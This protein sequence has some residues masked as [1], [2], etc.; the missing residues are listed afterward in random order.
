M[1]KPEVV[2]EENL[3]VETLE[4][5]TFELSISELDLVGGGSYV[6]GLG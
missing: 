3:A 2:V 6:L 1:N 4:Q 5:N